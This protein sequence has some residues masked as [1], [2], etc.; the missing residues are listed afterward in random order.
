MKTLKPPKRHLTREEKIQFLLDARGC[1][2]VRQYCRG[3]GI[4][5]SVFYEWSKEFARHIPPRMDDSGAVERENTI[6]RMKFSR[7]FVKIRALRKSH[8]RIR[9]FPKDEAAVNS[10][11]FGP[12][13][14]GRPLKGTGQA[15]P[16]APSTTA[17]GRQRRRPT[18]FP[19]FEVQRSGNGAALPAP[20]PRRTAR[21][22]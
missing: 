13:H 21:R 19:K 20:P 11:I 9:R 17:S 14:E 5:R 22:A 15:M 16:A 12:H 3:K 6:L 2:N 7:A 1:A 10:G 4:A 18:L 8:S